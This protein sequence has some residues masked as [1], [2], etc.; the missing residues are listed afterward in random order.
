[1]TNAG[2]TPLTAGP[3][4]FDVSPYVILPE[5]SSAVLAAPL[6]LALLGFAV[7]RRAAMN[8]S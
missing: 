6:A 1:M 7:R 8:A 2:L 5:P 3:T 4:F